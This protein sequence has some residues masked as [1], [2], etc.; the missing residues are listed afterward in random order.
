MSHILIIDDVAA[1]GRQYALDLE[2]LGGHR[3]T[4]VGRARDGLQVLESEPVDCVLLDLEMPVMDGYSA[5]REIRTREAL[6]DLP[7]IAMT[8]RKV[9]AWG[10]ID[11]E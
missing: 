10:E 11:R 1:M 7:V 6:R 4:Y 8:I 9:N 3:T 2:R 5:A